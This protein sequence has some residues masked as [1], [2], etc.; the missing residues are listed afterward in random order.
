VVSKVDCAGGGMVDGTVG[1]RRSVGTC[2]LF[3][4]FLPLPI[5]YLFG[6]RIGSLTE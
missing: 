4:S 6:L 1:L 2:V 5:S 3:I